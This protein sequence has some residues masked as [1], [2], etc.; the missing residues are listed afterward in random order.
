MPGTESIDPV[1]VA[2]FDAMA[3][4]WWDRSG[5]FAPLHA[6]NPTRMS[7]IT[8]QVCAEF[9]RDPKAPHPL[10]GLSVVDVGCGGGLACEP[11]HRLGADVTGVDAAEESIEVARRHAEHHGIGVAY[12]NLAAETLLEEGRSFDVVLALEIV[13]HVADPAS[14]LE[15]CA[16][17]VKPGGLL[18]VSTLNRT[19]RSH[20]LAVFAAE[21][22]LGW[23]PPGTHDW[24]KF[25]TPNE[26]DQML[27]SAGVVP[28]DHKGMIFSPLTGDWSLSATDLSINYIAAAQK[29]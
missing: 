18:F 3:Q 22:V 25:V 14:F 28:V 29:A 2:K 12:R 13:E 17:L 11:M 10:A 27:S 16:A 20:L 6:M 7:Y 9:G 5:K 24:N 19:V 1:E 23:L 21:R 4:E 15:V 8:H 26:L